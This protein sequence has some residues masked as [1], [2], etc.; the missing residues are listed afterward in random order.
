MID[1]NTIYC[2]DCIKGLQQ[3]DN[4]TVDL[5]FADPPFNLGK[6]YGNYNDERD[7]YYE[8]CHDWI[9]C[10]KKVLKPTG[11]IY[12]MNVQQNIW[13]IQKSF[14]DHDFLFRNIIIWKNSSMPV[15]NRFCINYQPILF[16]TKSK[17]YTFNYNAE[18]HISKAVLPWGR[19]NKGNLMIDQWDDIPFV[20]GG[21]MASKEAILRKDSKAKAHPCQMPIKLIE[22]ILK[23]STNKNDIVVDPFI[24]SGTTAVACKKLHRHFIGFEINPEY[25]EIAKKRIFNYSSIDRWL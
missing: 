6:K 4:E 20:P 15:K 21:C 7:D 12:I 3:I 24:G 13:M 23:F 19:R 11:S 25:V 16:Y 22:R 14:E 17:K 10:C 1:F 5:I 9:G 8:W 18:H 2:I